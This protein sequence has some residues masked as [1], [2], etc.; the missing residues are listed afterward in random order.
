MFKRTLRT[1]REPRDSLVPT[2][3]LVGFHVTEGHPG[4]VPKALV[5]GRLQ[6][7]SESE[8]QVGAEARSDSRG[9]DVSQETEAED[10]R[11]DGPGGRE[12]LECSGMMPEWGE[13]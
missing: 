1:I 8:M 3:F 7:G 12:S 11:K 4:S 5:E 6:F 9:K 2:L 13:Q 10:G